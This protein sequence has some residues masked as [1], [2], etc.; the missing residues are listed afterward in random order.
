MEMSGPVGCLYQGIAFLTC[1]TEDSTLGQGVPQLAGFLGIQRRT[2]QVKF[3]E[4]RKRAQLP[5]S[6]ERD[7]ASVHEQL[8]ELCQCQQMNQPLIADTEGHLEGCLVKYYLCPRVAR[9]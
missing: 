5:Q 4:V 6:L 8:T 3:P 1:S 7:R 9:R 2:S